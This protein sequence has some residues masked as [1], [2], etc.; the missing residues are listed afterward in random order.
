MGPENR[1]VKACGW[2]SVNAPRKIRST[3]VKKALLREKSE[4]QLGAWLG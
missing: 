2:E 4:T 3:Q 1:E